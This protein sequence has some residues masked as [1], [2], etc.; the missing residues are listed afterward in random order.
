MFSKYL[1]LVYLWL[2][3]LVIGSSSSGSLNAQI[4]TLDPI[5]HPKFQEPL[6]VPAVLDVRTGGNLNIKMKKSTQW[7]GLR[8]PNG[9]KLNTQVFGYGTGV[10]TYP[11][12]TILAKRNAAL[13]VLWDNKLPNAHLLP[14]DYSLHMAEWPANAGIPAVAHLHGGH[15]ESA[16]DGLPEAWY[17]RNFSVKGPDWVKATYFYQ[18]DQ[19]AATL[20]Y[21][22]HALGIT[23]LNTYAG[24][25]GFYLLTDDNE[26]ALIAQNVLPDFGFGLSIQDRMFTT[27]GGLFMPF[28]G[29]ADPVDCPN[30][31]N[32]DPLPMPSIVAE[33]FGD[34]ILVNGMAWPYQNVEPRKY[35]Y[36]LLNGSDSR[37]YN[38][39][40]SNGMPIM[41]IGTDNGL[42]HQPV[43]ATSLI[44]GPGE[45]YDIILD[46][47]NFAN[48]NVVLQNTGPD[49]PYRGNNGN[50][51]VTRP[52]GQI[53]QFRVGAT[54]TVPNATITASTIL[55]PAIAPLPYDENTVVR[56]LVLFEA[57]DQF[58]RLR[59]QLGIYD[60]DA[61][62]MNGS[63][64]WDEPITENP[65]LNATEI[66][67]IYNTTM[68]AHP[69][70][71][72]LVSFQIL[73]RYGHSGM[74]EL[75][76]Y[77][78]H[79]M[80]SKLVMTNPGTLTSMGGPA[81]HEDGWKDT[82]IVPPDQMMRVIAKFDLPGLYVWH[83]HILSHEDHE[84]MRPFYVGPMPV[85]PPMS[86]GFVE[87]EEE[88]ELEQ[89][90][91]NP[92]SEQTSIR[93]TLPARSEVQL[94]VFDI[95][96]QLIGVLARGMFPAGEHQMMW[97]G[98]DAG[99]KPVANG[100]YFYRLVAGDQMLTKSLSLIR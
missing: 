80:G 52:T 85:Q 24:L 17:T 30:G 67:E 88:L 100:V 77:D 33:F 60:P 44:M 36:R 38:F 10:A 39:Q 22:D 73:G 79:G 18:N 66:W 16:S 87:M 69:M 74:A 27:G 76:G 15:T 57:R 62:T 11:G 48:T 53:M 72:H 70:H 9:K 21:H 5:L 2:A 26:E 42:L 61:G 25:A 4:P 65:D 99:G 6:P 86:P 14:I 40:L 63:L 95:N 78:P 43:M 96:G 47:T 56:K 13:N 54:A 7:L 71:L 97:D 93:F 8:A 3:C 55:R 51:D 34:F 59:P 45:R 32:P 89:N 12:P 41:V 1:P 64:L 92:F 84:M 20:W 35:R 46:F 19:E 75:M 28:M 37:F 49:E 90:A 94:Q 50:P 68:D 29:M 98:N 83:C 31:A 91:P 23:R 82:G 58:C 81:A